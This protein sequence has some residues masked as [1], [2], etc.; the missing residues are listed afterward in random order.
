MGAQA[1]A[2][3]ADW[4]FAAC[5]YRCIIPAA[6]QTFPAEV[7]LKDIFARNQRVCHSLAI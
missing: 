7:V 3:R 4:L 1:R 5:H 2:V 6:R